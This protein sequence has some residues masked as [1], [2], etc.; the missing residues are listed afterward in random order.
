MVEVTDAGGTLAGL[1]ASSRLPILSIDAGWRGCTR[2][3]AGDRRWW[4]LAIGHVPAEAGRPSVTF[5]RA[6]ARGVTRYGRRPSAALPRAVEGLWVASD[7][8]WVAAAAGHYSQVR[9]T[10]QASTQLQRLH[11]V[12]EHG[13]CSA[14]RGFPPGRGSARAVAPEYGVTRQA[15]LLDVKEALVDEFVDAEGA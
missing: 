1:V 11:P 5:T 12:P 14:V 6:R 13:R 9:L 4:V 10:T 8:L 7:G 3:P 2:D 15:L